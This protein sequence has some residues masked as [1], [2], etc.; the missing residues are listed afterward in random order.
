MAL[1]QSE[2]EKAKSITNEEMAVAADP[3]KN[4]DCPHRQRR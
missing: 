2:I 1:A 4:R 3:Q